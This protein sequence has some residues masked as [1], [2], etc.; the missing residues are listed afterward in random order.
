MWQLEVCSGEQQSFP[1]II[2]AQ[3]SHHLTTSPNGFRPG[4]GC[5]RTVQESCSYER[6]YTRIEL[7]EY[8]YS[9]KSYADV[10]LE[11]TLTLGFVWFVYSVCV[12]QLGVPAF[13][14]RDG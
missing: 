3:R 1:C 4:N 8:C 10:P 9:F 2:R 13:T 7:K 6:Q 11:P 5:V 12:D 14:L